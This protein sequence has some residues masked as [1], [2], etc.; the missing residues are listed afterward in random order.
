MGHDEDVLNVI[1]LPFGI[2]GSI[3]FDCSF[4]GSFFSFG[5]DCE[6]G[7]DGLDYGKMQ[8]Y[9]FEICGIFN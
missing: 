9:F 4:L 3:G 6:C 2:V 5:R 7:G 1:K 8:R